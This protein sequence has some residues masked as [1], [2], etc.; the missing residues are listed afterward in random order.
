MSINNSP[1]KRIK[2]PLNSNMNVVPYIDV[3]LVLLVIFMVT[4][5]LLTTGVE[6]NL[7]DAKAQALTTTQEL[8]VVISLKDDASLYVSQDG[9]ED[10]LV[11]RAE[12]IDILTEIQTNKPSTSVLINADQANL[13]GQ[14][15]VLMSALQ[16]A[17][18]TQVGLLTHSLEQ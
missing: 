8:P 17:G 2:K 7:P 10:K 18:I 11:S 16:Q 14:V 5:P 9:E 12:L 6:V 4:A 15:M 3:M 13:Y 1:F